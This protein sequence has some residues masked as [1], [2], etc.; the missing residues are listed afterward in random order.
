MCPFLRVQKRDR[1][2]TIPGP[3][4]SP[5]KTQSRPYHKNF[6][7]SSSPPARTSIFAFKS[8]PTPTRSPPRM[9][10][11]TSKPTPSNPSS[12]AEVPK[13]WV[14]V[15]DSSRFPQPDFGEST[16]LSP[17]LTVVSLLLRL[18]HLHDVSLRD[19]FPPLLY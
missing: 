5:R 8:A 12:S 15:K 3:I 13:Y 10:A 16:A 18:H 7:L 4:C 14:S 11:T 19:A 1:R 9:R 17:T 2:S 6:P